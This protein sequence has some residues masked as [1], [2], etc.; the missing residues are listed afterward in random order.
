[1]AEREAFKDK[2]WAAMQRTAAKMGIEADENCLQSISLYADELRKWNKAYNLVGR[3]LSEEGLIELYKDAISALSVRGL[4]DGRKEVLDIGSGAGLPGIPLYLAAG[5]F[6]LTLL[7]SQRKKITFLRH[8]CRKL[9]LREVRVHAGRLE[10]MAK[11]EDQL[12]AY[13]VGLARAVMEPLRLARMAVPLLCDGGNL[14]LYVGKS[15]A[16]K[17]RR[18]SLTLGGR[19]LELQKIKSTQRIVGRENYL[20]VMRKVARRASGD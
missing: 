4:F 13:D 8:I 9:E 19:G 2:L 20:A 18:S 17:I 15:E 11:E 6:P 7:E 16:D 12:T 14:V 3:K 10:D 1:M 5:P